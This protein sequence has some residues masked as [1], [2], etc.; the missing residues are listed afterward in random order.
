MDVAYTP[1]T[2]GKPYTLSAQTVGNIL[3][4]HGLFPAP[5][6]KKTTTWNEFI[7]AHMDMLVAT[8]FFTAEVWTLGGLVTY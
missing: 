1:N 4:R 7:R 5:E 2:I 6:R 3:K 8:D